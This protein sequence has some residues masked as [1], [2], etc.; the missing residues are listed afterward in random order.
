MNDAPP[1][2]VVITGAAH[3][4][5]RAVAAQ[6]AGQGHRAL[7]SARDGHA[8]ARAADELGDAV[9]PLPALDLRDAA[10]PPW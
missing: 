5:G 3:G 9:T 2:V 6:L 1:P 7:I 8:A 4:L 10:P